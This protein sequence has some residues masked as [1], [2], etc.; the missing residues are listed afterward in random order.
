M[1]DVSDWTYICVACM[2]VAKRNGYGFN[3]D[4]WLKVCFVGRLE[5][6]KLSQLQQQIGP[7]TNAEWVTL[8]SLGRPYSTDLSLDNGYAA[9]C[10]KLQLQEVSAKLL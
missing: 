7:K 6:T 4:Y 10:L 5:A 8:V 9:Y 1:K 3:E 2:S